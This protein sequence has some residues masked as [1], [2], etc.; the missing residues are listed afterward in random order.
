MFVLL[1]FSIGIG[2]FYLKWFINPSPNSQKFYNLFYLFIL[3]LF[4]HHIKFVMCGK[5]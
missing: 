1:S 5:V 3:L 4:K 2:N